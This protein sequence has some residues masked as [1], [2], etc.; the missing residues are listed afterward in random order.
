MLL[1]HDPRCKKLTDKRFLHRGYSFV[2]DLV[3]DYGGDVWENYKHF[4]SR[5]LWRAK[6]EKEIADRHRE[7]LLDK[8]G[9]LEEDL[10]KIN[11][12]RDIYY[13]DIELVNREYS[14]RKKITN[15]LKKHSYLRVDYQG[16]DDAFTT[17]VY[18]DDFECSIH[19]ENDPHQDHHYCD[20]YEEA[21]DRCLDYIEY[22]SKL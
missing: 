8:I 9:K 20:S 12:I 4:L 11:L 3:A 6:Y 10:K 21:H 18:S 1:K 15:L 17:W 14:F 16:D 2:Y 5:Y 22:H 19:D 7:Y 13:C